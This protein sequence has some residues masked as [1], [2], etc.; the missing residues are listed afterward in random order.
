MEFSLLTSADPYLPR[1]S[2][3]RQN[4]RR[5]LAAMAEKWMNYSLFISLFYSSR[6]S[7]NAL[8]GIL[9]TFVKT[10]WQ[11]VRKEYLDFAPSVSFCP[12]HVHTPPASQSVLSTCNVIY[13][14]GF[15]YLNPDY[16][17]IY[18]SSPELFSEY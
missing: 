9:T 14:H 5:E 4:R 11:A 3:L 1:D 12:S 16:S 15:N 17:P 6:S 13:Y 7:Q 2:V 10:E 18:I 8:R